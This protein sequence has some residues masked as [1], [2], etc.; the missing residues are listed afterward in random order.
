MPEHVD[1]SAINKNQLEDL[2]DELP[3]NERIPRH[4][5]EMA[6]N[7]P[8]EIR[9]FSIAT[10]LHAQGS[11]RWDQFQSGLIE[12]IRTWEAEHHTTGDWDYYERWLLALEG[13][14]ESLGLVEASELEV[15]THEVLS[16]PANR[17]HH[18]AARDP[19]GISPAVTPDKD[20]VGR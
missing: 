20:M 8:W 15:R 19:V 2:V 17:N 16:T 18:E 5:G 12:S 9:A 14:V 4:S 3:F 6:F 11:F 1:T 10:A 7:H 13:L